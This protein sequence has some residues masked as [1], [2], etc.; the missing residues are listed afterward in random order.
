MKH[1]LPWLPWLP[2]TIL[3]ERLGL[4][5]HLDGQLAIAKLAHKKTASE[6]GR[7]LNTGY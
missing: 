4:L 2:W 7:R 1:F 6:S 3:V 5:D